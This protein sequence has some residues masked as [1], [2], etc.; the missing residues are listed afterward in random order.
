MFRTSAADKRYARIADRIQYLQLRTAE[1][2]LDTAQ[3]ENRMARR[4][5]EKAGKPWEPVENEEGM[6]TEGR[7]GY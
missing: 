7:F 6:G 2:E 4:E 5:Y 3:I 1:L